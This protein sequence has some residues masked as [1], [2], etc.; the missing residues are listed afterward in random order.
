MLRTQK[1]NLTKVFSG[2]VFA[3]FLVFILAAPAS[4]QEEEADED[5][6]AIAEDEILPEVVVVEDR[7]MTSASD[8]EVRRKDF[9][10]L[11]RQNPSDLVR[12]IP[13]VHVSQ[14]TGG[15]KAYQYFL[16]GFDA[17]H[18]QDLAAYLDGIPLNEPSQVHGHGYLDLHFLIPETLS[19]IQIIKGP[20]DPEHGN[21]A[22]A[23]AINFIPR[24]TG[25]KSEV[26]L[27]GGMYN[28]VR[29]LGTFA[30]DSKTYMLVGALEGD[31]TDGYTDPGD[32]KAFRA[33]TGQ[34]LMMGN[35]SLNLMSH[36]YGQDS[37]ATDVVPEKW[38]DDGIIDR[39][40]SLDDSDKVTSNR[41][42]V[43]LTVDRENGPSEARIQGYYDYKRSTIWSNY[44]FYL[45]HPELGDQQE[46]RDSRNVGG[47]NLRYRHLLKWGGALFQTSA[48]AQWR[49]DDVD[50]VLANTAERE[51]FNVIN[52]LQFTE[53][54][55]GV[56]LRED[57][58]LTKWLTIIPGV[59][60]D[61]ISYSGSGTQDDR[62]FNVYTNTADTRQ[63]VERDW[64]ETAQIV[65]PKA[66][67]IL[68]PVKPWNI[69]VN[70]GEGFFSNTTLQMANDPKS[71]IP[72]VR[73]GE[74]G[75]RLKLFGNRLNIAA[76]A[77]YAN[78]EEDLVFDPQTGLSLLKEK[79][80]RKGLDSELRIYPARWLYLMTDASW[81]DARFAESG[82]RIPNGP[83][84]LMTNGIGWRHESGV[85]GMI[86]GRYMGERELDQDDWAPPFYV[87]DLVAGYD[88]EHWG[89][90]AAV[91]NVL[92]TEWE[93]AVFS[94]ETRPEKNGDTHS[95]IHW[96]PGTP[97]FARLT[98]TAR[99]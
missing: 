59:R 23:G 65:S 45:F 17:E 48:G 81:V 47:C 87:T 12:I 39:Y 41:H 16:R 77:W 85:R 4:G 21:F 86:R 63:D 62:Y 57:L 14:H 93:D 56:W 11:P 83:I 91:D 76:S 28:T 66:S 27:S 82:D 15:A 50:Q 71:S 73:G 74:V 18:G 67:L 61:A 90:E 55:I 19:S 29:A 42:I 40:E 30:V 13:G 46:M 33:N 92:N 84:T 68:T 64:D 22:T 10:N 99:F 70:Y 69:F 36:H 6:D 75:T 78:K 79:T 98:A 60:W 51:R 32:A 2:I 53:N 52:D 38:V 88:A 37:A 89:L 31:R 34:T 97:I 94:Y 95:G 3:F 43:G 25:E 1:T 49:L 58:I 44:T 96:T 80:E 72:K 7:A 24:R 5:A 35:W 54:A 9:E 26:S 8:S 20:Y